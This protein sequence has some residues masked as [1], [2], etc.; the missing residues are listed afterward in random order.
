M[1]QKTE[2]YNPDS[3]YAAEGNEVAYLTN[4]IGSGAAHD[5]MPPYKTV[6]MW[7]RIG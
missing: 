5:N 7:K 3:N 1:G 4:F 2:M 6:Y